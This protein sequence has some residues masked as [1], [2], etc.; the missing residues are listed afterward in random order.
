MNVAVTGHRPNKLGHDYHYTSQRSK[1]IMD[2]VETY[3]SI[4]KPKFVYVGMAQGFDSMVA[5]VCIKMKIPF[6]AAIPFIGQE[7]KWPSHGQKFYFELLSKA[8]NIHVC[9]I[10]VDIT[11]NEW[12]QMPEGKYNDKVMQKR[13]E[14]L[15]DRLNPTED[16]LLACHDGTS[17]GTHNC[18]KYAES[19][20]KIIDYINLSLCV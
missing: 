8:H 11:Y 4:Y 2:Q 7:M 15:V 20:H 5:L 1:C 18:I 9:D 12:K 3:F 17:G 16:R 10:G 13:N 14:W 6:I 19:Q